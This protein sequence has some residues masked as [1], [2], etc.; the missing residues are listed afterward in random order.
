VLTLDACHAGSAAK[1]VAGIVPS[2]AA[3]GGVVMFLSSGKDQSSYP[4]EKL[5]RS[6]FT[7]FLVTGLG[8]GAAGADRTV[9][10]SGLFNYVS[11]RMK[12]WSLQSGKLQTPL[13]VGEA[14]ADLVLARCPPRGAIVE[15]P[16]PPKTTNG[17]TVDQPWENSLGMKFVPVPGTTCL[18]SIWETRVRD[19][20]AFVK[21]TSYDATVGMFS[22]KSGSWGRNGDTW[23]S[24]GFTQGPT[25]PVCGV[26]WDDAQAFC[27]W[28][29]EK[30]RRE[31]K[32]QAGQ[33]YRLPT[34]LEWSKVVRLP[35]ETGSTPAERSGEIADVY[36]WGT[37]WPPP[38]EAGNYAGEEAGLGRKIEGYNDGHTR[39]S[40]VGSF[41]ANRYGLYDMGGNVWEWC[42]D[43]YDR[44]SGARVLRGGSWNHLGSR[45]LLSSYRNYSLPVNRRDRHGFRCVLMASS[46]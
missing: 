17:P 32:L 12:D 37:E 21:D 24:P 22:L 41:K 8:G 20:E 43:L 46:R 39:T 19:F 45:Y 29:T 15:P 25:H 9:T 38:K 34:D 4:D 5:G 40:P 6:V 3:S 23:K 44:L 30:E 42:E 28:L 26:S 16:V 35:A 31:G 36:P 7:H 14:Q 27:K 11:R 2:L 13:L 1:G 10:A 18:F 33:S